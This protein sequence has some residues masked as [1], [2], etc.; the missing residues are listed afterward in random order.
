MA[1]TNPIGVRFDED[2]LKSLK[3]DNLADSPQKALNYLSEFYRLN[4]EKID[5]KKMFE[6]SALFNRMRPTDDKETSALDKAQ[7]KEFKQKKQESPRG[8]MP[9]P[10]NKAAYLKWLRENH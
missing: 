10:S 4:R 2:L 7:S 3:D 1:K 6:D 8:S 5:F 9:D